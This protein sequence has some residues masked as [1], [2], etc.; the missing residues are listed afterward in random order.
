MTDQ[1]A[2]KPTGVEKT[3]SIAPEIPGAKNAVLPQGSGPEELF[4]G[5]PPAHRCQASSLAVTH[6][7]GHRFHDLDRLPPFHARRGIRCELPD[8]LQGGSATAQQ[9]G[10][11]PARLTMEVPL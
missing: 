5:Q 7:R 9:A 1:A 2:P 10:H 6:N 4:L 11:D 8:H 3:A